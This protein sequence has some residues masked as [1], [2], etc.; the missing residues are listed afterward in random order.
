MSDGFIFVCYTS[1]S[2]SALLCVALASTGVAGQPEE[3][4]HPGATATLGKPAW[5]EDWQTRDFESILREPMRYGTTPNGVFGSKLLLEESIDIGDRLRRLSGNHDPNTA[6]VFA[7]TFPEPRYLWITRRDK[8]RQA[9]SLFRAKQSGE[10]IRKV[11]STPAATN[12]VFSYRL[13]DGLLRHIVQT[14]AAWARFFIDSGIVPHTVV[15]EDL[16][17]TYEPTV[18][19]V[20]SYLQIPLPKEVSYFRTNH[21]EAVGRTVRGMGATLLRD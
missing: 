7:N 6:R 3:Y 9:I 21:S 13:I 4:F 20:L 1:R 16:V 18:R 15:Y 17:Q 10:W 14:E 8:V 2:G 12:L 11:E 19:Q 5:R